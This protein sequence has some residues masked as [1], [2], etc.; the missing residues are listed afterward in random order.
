MFYDCLPD[1]AINVF[2]A[3]IMRN[4]NVCLCSLLVVSMHACIKNIKKAALIILLT[5]YRTNKK[6]AGVFGR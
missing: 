4:A 5:A 2:W 3:V 6:P 1:F